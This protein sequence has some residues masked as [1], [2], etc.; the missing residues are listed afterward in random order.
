M[1]SNNT[2]IFHEYNP[3]NVECEKCQKL[4][5]MQ[6]T[7]DRQ[8]EDYHEFV[9]VCTQ[10]QQRQYVDASVGDF[11]RGVNLRIKTKNSKA[12]SQKNAFEYEW[13]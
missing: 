7:E 8:R 3:R 13:I 6:E 10:V 1:S 11:Y 5:K 12:N 4:C 2:N 9:K